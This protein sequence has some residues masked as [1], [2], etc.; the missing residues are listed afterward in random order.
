MYAMKEHRHRHKFCI[1]AY[2]QGILASIHTHAESVYVCIYVHIIRSYFSVV[3]IKMVS[4]VEA[5]HLL[6]STSIFKICSMAV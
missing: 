4:V 5:N 3:P 2:I 1:I 6:H